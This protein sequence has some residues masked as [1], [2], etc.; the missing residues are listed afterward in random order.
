[1]PIIKVVFATDAAAKAERLWDI[2][3]DIQSWPQWQGTSY[4]KSDKAGP[5]KEGSKFVAEL[6]GVKWY[7][8]VLKADKPNNI[9]WEARSLGLSAVHEWEFHEEAGKTSVVTRE[10]MHG[11]LLFL[12][13]PIIK[14]R[15]Q[16]Y[17]D[18]WLAALKSKAESLQA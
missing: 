10:N 7:L 3:T 5:L 12:T 2:L 15:L 8:S 13:Y 11:W 1:M 17:D 18:K 16:K 4:I 14:R 9:S 6:G